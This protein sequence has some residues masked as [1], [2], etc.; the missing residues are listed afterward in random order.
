[1]FMLGLW[2]MELRILEFRLKVAARMKSE[3]EISAEKF[4]ADQVCQESDQ[5][6]FWKLIKFGRL[7][8]VWWEKVLGFGYGV[9][10]WIL[11]VG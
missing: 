4:L 10:Y 5:D 7:D 9:G 1:M 6:F 8:G 11:E 3:S 2:V